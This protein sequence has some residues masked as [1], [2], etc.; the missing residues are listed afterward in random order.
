MEKVKRYLVFFLGL[1]ANALGVAFITKAA[2]GTSPIAAIP[3]VLSLILPKLTL[4]EWTIVFSFLLIFIQ[5]L[6]ERR[7]ANKVQLLLQCG[8]SFVFG[9]FIDLAM[10]ALRSLAPEQYLLKIVFLLIGCLITA[11]APTSKSL[12]TSPCSRAMPLSAPSP[13][14]SIRSTATCALSPTAA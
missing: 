4:G 11:F 13:V 5:L 14:R 9:Y 2:L 10:L 12:P 6:I 8:I 7:N 1:L 3:Y